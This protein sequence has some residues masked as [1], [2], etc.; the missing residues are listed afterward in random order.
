M[1]HTSEVRDSQAFYF[2]VVKSPA[3]L[4]PHVTPILVTY[5]KIWPATRKD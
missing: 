3:E 5:R 2:H 4:V 1:G